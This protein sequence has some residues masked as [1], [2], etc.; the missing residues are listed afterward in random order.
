MAG[1]KKLL[2]K[3]GR[4]TGFDLTTG[5]DPPKKYNVEVTVAKDHEDIMTDKG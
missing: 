4:N 1:Y 5:L 2:K 3:Y